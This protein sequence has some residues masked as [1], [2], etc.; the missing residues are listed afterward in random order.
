MED[1]TRLYRHST[2]LFYKYN[3]IAEKCKTADNTWVSIN[4]VRLYLESY[5]NL[6][7]QFQ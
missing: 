2:P 6:D 1:S 7:P 5:L 4:K 3:N